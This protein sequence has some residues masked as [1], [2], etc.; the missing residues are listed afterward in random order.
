MIKNSIGM[1]GQNAFNMCS[2]PWDWDRLYSKKL[3]VTLGPT[4]YFKGLVQCSGAWGLR[5]GIS[6]QYMLKT[7]NHFLVQNLFSLF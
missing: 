5:P 2:S 3:I 7:S 4:P 6:A 1:G